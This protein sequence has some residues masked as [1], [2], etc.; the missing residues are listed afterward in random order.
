MLL[1][2]LHALSLLQLPSGMH[3][4]QQGTVL[5]SN[6]SCLASVWGQGGAEGVLNALVLSGVAARSPD[7]APRGMPGVI[8]TVSAFAVSMAI[9]ST[10]AGV[11]YSLSGCIPT[12]L[13][14]N[15]KAAQVLLNLCGFRF[16][17]RMWFCSSTLSAL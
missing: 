4:S 1:K 15:R 8:M 12:L 10:A 2:G 16:V 13:S 5:D 17:G 9:R 3:L 7:Q 11:S 6:S 14:H